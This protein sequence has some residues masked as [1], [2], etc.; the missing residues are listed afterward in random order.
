MKCKCEYRVNSGI[1]VKIQLDKIERMS[2]EVREREGERDIALAT[3]SF[4]GKLK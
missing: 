3:L 2:V 4:L 1:V